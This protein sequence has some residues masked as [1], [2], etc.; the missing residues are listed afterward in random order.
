MK[1]SLILILII[2]LISGCSLKSE[3]KPINNLD[4]QLTLDLCLSVENFD[5]LTDIIQ[6]NG[7]KSDEYESINILYNIM[8]IQLLYRIPKEGFNTISVTGKKDKIFYWV[9][10]EN[11]SVS[12]QTKDYPKNIGEQKYIE[13]KE[14]FCELI[15][16]IN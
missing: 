16:V 14:H 10:K 6:N 3:K 13:A 12:I 2:L 8:D 9:V 15:K 11:N 4:D 5:K 7:K 1:K